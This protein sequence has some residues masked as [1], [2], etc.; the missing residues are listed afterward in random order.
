M[1]IR[2]FQLILLGIAVGCLLLSSTFAA[3]GDSAHRLEFLELSALLLLAVIAV[4]S[5]RK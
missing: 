5:V 1:R 4:G 2:T 3:A